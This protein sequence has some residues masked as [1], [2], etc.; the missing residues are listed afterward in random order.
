MTPAWPLYAKPPIDLEVLLDKLSLLG[1]ARVIV[2][3][4]ELSVILESVVDL[5]QTATSTKTMPSG[6]TLVTLASASKEFEFHLD[7]GESRS[8][9]FQR[10]G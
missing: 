8:R 3:R 9:S 7:K 1:S 10:C 6:K 5:S 2:M 4:P